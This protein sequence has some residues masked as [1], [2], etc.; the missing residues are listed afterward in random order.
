MRDRNHHLRRACFAHQP[1][2]AQEL[3]R[4]EVRR[5]TARMDAMRRKTTR[6]KGR[7]RRQDGVV[8]E[9]HVLA[10]MERRA[11][12][13]GCWHHRT[14]RFGDARRRRGGASFGIVVHVSQR[15][16]ARRGSSVHVGRSRIRHASE[17]SGPWKR[18]TQA[19]T[20]IGTSPIHAGARRWTALEPSHRSRPRR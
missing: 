19:A 2:S 12:T 3:R 13:R 5:S 18:P 9:R 4:G 11:G 17:A 8:R 20:A 10:S 6:E 14:L 16:F 15:T 1:A 7:K